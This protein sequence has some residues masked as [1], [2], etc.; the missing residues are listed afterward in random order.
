LGRELV[1]SPLGVDGV[2]DAELPQ[3]LTPTWQ[4]RFGSTGAALIG[5]ALLTAALAGKRHV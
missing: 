1:A 3:A 4:S 2:L 5:L